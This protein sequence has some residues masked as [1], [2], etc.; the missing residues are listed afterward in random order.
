[1]QRARVQRAS[2]D[3]K[4]AVQR[5]AGVG[6]W[7][8]VKHAGRMGYAD[9]WIRLQ[10]LRPSVRSVRDRRSH[11]CVPR[12]P[13][14]QSREAVVESWHG[15]RVS[16]TFGARPADGRVRIRRVRL[17]DEYELGSLLENPASIS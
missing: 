11:A 15:R 5:A 2:C 7:A 12:M 16:G 1:V 13:E 8:A 3:V 4:R 9:F 10:G 6:R 14:R 17:S